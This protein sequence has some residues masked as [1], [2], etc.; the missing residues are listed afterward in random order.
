MTKQFITLEHALALKELGFTGHCLGQYR[1]WDG[2]AWLEY[3]FDE[4][5][6]SNYTIECNAPLYQ[7][8]FDFFREHGLE[9]WISAELGY[10]KTTYSYHVTGRGQ[11]SFSMTNIES[12]DKAKELL[13]N[14]LINILQKNITKCI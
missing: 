14:T 9:S 12:M 11:S 4:T 7:Q 3:E 10:W 8:A 1:Q 13:L 2:Q 6:S 5:D